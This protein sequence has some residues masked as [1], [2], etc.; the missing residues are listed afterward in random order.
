LLSRIIAFMS[1]LAH[2]PQKVIN[3]FRH[4]AVRYAAALG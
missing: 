4:P 1:D 3:Y 2:A